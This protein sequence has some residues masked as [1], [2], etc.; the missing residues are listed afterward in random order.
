MRS[1]NSSSFKFQHR[2]HAELLELAKANRDETFAAMAAMGMKVTADT[3]P[4]TDP[5]QPAEKATKSSYT[6][7]Q[8]KDGLEL[9]KTGLS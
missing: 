4:K 7:Q 2:T 5:V 9:R 6:E 3:T 1:M 8:I